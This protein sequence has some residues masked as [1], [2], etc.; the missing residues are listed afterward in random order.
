M[1]DKPWTT[2]WPLQTHISYMYLDPFLHIEMEQENDLS[3]EMGVNTI[4]DTLCVLS[5]STIIVRCHSI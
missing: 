2:V 3:V 4:L 5:F 1:W